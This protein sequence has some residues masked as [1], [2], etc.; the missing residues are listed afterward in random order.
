MVWS[1]PEIIKALK[2][3]YKAGKDL[4]YNAL[5]RR[6]QSLVSAA[7]YH[8]GSYREAV[9]AAGIDYAEVVRRP[10]W[11]KP[12]IIRLIK[13]ARRPGQA[14]P[15]DLPII[16]A[17]RVG[18]TMAAQPRP[19]GSRITCLST[20]QGAVNPCVGKKSARSAS[21]DGANAGAPPAWICP[22]VAES[23][24]APEASAAARN[25]SDAR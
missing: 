17:P 10:R 6:Q 7:A 9:G 24:E 14:W 20:A 5:A 4:S 3:L 25:H 21:G 8:F 1:K 23:D 11:T 16:V 22:E 13:S 2:K 12:L 18:M 15:S 19:L